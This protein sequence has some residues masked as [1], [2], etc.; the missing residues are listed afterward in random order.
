MRLIFLKML[1]T[2]GFI[3][4]WEDIRSYKIRPVPSDTQFHRLK[5][6]FRYFSPSII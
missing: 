4:F 3:G 6:L 1:V 5:T 2:A